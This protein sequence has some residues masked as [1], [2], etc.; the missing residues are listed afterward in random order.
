MLEQIKKLFKKQNDVE[1]LEETFI[2]NISDIREN[3][4][5]YIQELYDQ[6]IKIVDR[7]F[8]QLSKM[9]K[10]GLEKTS[11]NG[12]SKFEIVLKT[13]LKCDTY[14]STKFNELYFYSNATDLEIWVKK[15]EKRVEIW[16][17]IG[18][19]VNF[20]KYDNHVIIVI[21]W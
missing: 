20:S 8:F 4:R 19:N 7:E 12:C 2:P 11:L 6:N 17:N 16:K 18:Y 15:L 1:I 3:N 21:A 10:D 14:F 9:I 5:Q 13:H